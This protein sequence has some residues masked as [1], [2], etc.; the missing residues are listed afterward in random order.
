NESQGWTQCSASQSSDFHLAGDYL[1]GGLFSLHA[2][3]VGRLNLSQPVVPM[4]QVYNLKI[5]GYSYLRA[6]RFAVE[7]INN[8][9][10]LLP[11]VS[12]GYEMVDVCYLTNSIH[13]ILYF[14][15]NKHSVVQLHNNYTCYQPRVL[16]I[17]GPDS[18]EAAVIVA[19]ILNLFLIPQ[20]SYRA[21]TDELNNRERFPSAFR[22][23]SS[24]EQQIVAM[25]LLLKEFQWTWINVIYS[26]DDYGRQNLKL[27]R[28]QTTGIC[29][30][31]QETIPV[32]RRGQ[33]FS[34]DLQGKIRA[35]VSKIT[36]STATV[37]IVLSLELT[38][39]F[40]FQEAVRQ[41]VT[42]LVWIAAEAWAIDHTLYNLTDLWKVGTILGVAAKEITIPGFDDF[43]VSLAGGDNGQ[44]SDQNTCNQVC[45]QCLRVARDI[46]QHLRLQGERIDFNV[47]SSVYIV[48]H[49][50]H[51]LLDCNATGC[52]KRMVYPWQLVPEVSSVDFTLLNKRINF[53]ENG[54]T[55]NSFEIIQWQWNQPYC[56][57]KKI[58][59]YSAKR[60]KLLFN[61]HDISWHTPNNMVPI[62]VCSQKCGPGQWLKPIGFYSCCFECIDCESGTFLNNSDPYNCQPCP[63]DQ[64]S[65]A[66]SQDCYP[67][68]VEYLE[69]QEGPTVA[70][71]LF[72]MLGLIAILVMSV[73]FAIHSH[74]PVVKSAGGRM[75]FFMMAS[76]V[77]GFLS[78]PMYVGIPTV[79]KCMCRQTAFSLCFTLCLSCITVRSFQIICVFKMATRLPKAYNYWKKYNGQY[80]FIAVVLALKSAIITTNI[81]FNFPA[82]ILLD[83]EDDPSIVVL[84]CNERDNL[85]LLSNSSLD[86]FLSILC[87]YFA[88]MGKEL[89]KNYNEAKYITLCMTSYF[90]SWV[91]VF[92]IR[93][94]YQGV[95]VTIFDAAVVV[96]N[97]LGLSMGYFGPK[98]YLIFFR[99][100]CNTAAYFQTSIQSYTMRQD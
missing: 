63:T 62:S 45:D 44:A 85:R 61:P 75:C 92:L 79:F 100:E 30:A 73:I 4:C 46:D 48:A 54:D 16:A 35:V 58:A 72:S 10:T 87:F 57:F 83:V 40:F 47:Y 7:E 80:I 2:E 14:L 53:R 98:C 91:A 96:I 88:Y 69:W 99:P 24:M 8:S 33:L 81:I 84:E 11:G 90:V 94:I 49:A 64:W 6:M 51:K 36:H 70:L 32:L 52:H 50:L 42:D 89:P 29:V 68:L 3:V 67:R 55:P 71:L 39:Q 97:L 23:I 59:S 9:S 19:D 78:I 56:P 21:T 15:S 86:M 41:N 66:R 77:I 31:L 38:L 22:A 25:L 26:D 43:R 1:L 37:V 28:A 60:Q 74:T 18:S 27:L 34:E 13:P 95:L 5:V 12:L 17:I 65:N 20:V 82:P 93:S 76:L